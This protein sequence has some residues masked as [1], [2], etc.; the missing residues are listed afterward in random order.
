[1][2]DIHSPSIAGARAAQSAPSSAPTGSSTEALF[3]LMN[4]KDRVEAELK[5]LGSVLDSV[6]LLYRPAAH[7]FVI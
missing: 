2:D 3:E 4:E 7:L 5:A 1:M 6:E